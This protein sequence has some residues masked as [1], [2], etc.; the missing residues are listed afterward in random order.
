MLNKHY[1]TCIW[2]ISQGWA[3]AEEVGHDVANCTFSIGHSS[4]NQ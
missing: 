2:K 3:E 1:T 4:S